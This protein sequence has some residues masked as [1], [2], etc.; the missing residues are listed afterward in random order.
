MIYNTLCRII[1]FLIHQSVFFIKSSLGFWKYRYVQDFH[2]RFPKD[3]LRWL[4]Y[5]SRS[6]S[7]S[8]FL[9]LIDWHICKLQL[10]LDGYFSLN[11]LHVMLIFLLNTYDWEIYQNYIWVII[12]YHSAFIYSHFY[13]KSNDISV[14]WHPEFQIINNNNY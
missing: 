2:E 1:S 7:V 14:F 10:N 13:N 4:H 11:F 12:F 3:F 5:L 6:R 9:K 8:V